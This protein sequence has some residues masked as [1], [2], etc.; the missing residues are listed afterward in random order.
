MVVRHLDHP[1][2]WGT[3]EE[4]ALDW[5]RQN[6]PIM[7]HY[8][9]PGDP[10]FET[11]FSHNAEPAGRVAPAEVAPRAWYQR[12]TFPAEHAFRTS[13][14]SDLGFLEL[15]INDDEGTFLG[16][17]RLVRT[18]LPESL[19][20]RLGRGDQRLFERMDRVSEP[21]RRPAGILFADL[22]AS[23]VLSRRLSSRA[24]FDLISGL[25]DLID[26][27]VVERDGIVGKHAGDGGSALFLAADFGGS[28]SAAARAAIE[29]ARA[30]RDGA[31]QLGPGDVPVQVNVGVHW[32]ATLMVG[33]VATRGRLEV[34]ALGDQMNEAARSRP[35]RR[36]ARSSPPRISSS[37]ST[38]PT[39]RPP[40]STPTPSPTRRSAS[41]TASARRRSATPARSRSR[42]S[43]R[44]AGGA[45]V[46][47]PPS[48]MSRG[49]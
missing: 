11:I 34:T 35:R 18:T 42:A 36:A 16:V 40:A 38:Q 21:G 5:W 14:L 37:A 12:V 24:Y 29:A 19:L 10:D 45:G 46:P 6:V 7:R 4:T 33:Q 15:R 27:C 20:T 9:H 1:M 28:E 13:V 22:E 3:D 25:T 17:V 44:D 31:A 41:W 2:I 48:F 23:G 49:R 30:I 43:E 47:A 32:G 8:L 39:P 26:S